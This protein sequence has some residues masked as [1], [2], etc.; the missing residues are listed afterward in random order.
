MNI[1]VEVS[2]FMKVITLCPAAWESNSYLLIQNGEA[3]L[4]DAGASPDK[5]SEALAREQATLKGILLTHGHFDH[6]L[7]I[8]ALREKYNVPVYVH[9]EDAPMLTD[10]RLNA[11]AFFFR[12]ERSWRPAEKL[13]SDG[14]S[15]PFGD[16]R[17]SVIHTPGHTRGSV[18][19]LVGDLLFSGDTLFADGYG[20]TDLEGGDD[21]ALSYSLQKLFK[22]PMTLK[23]YAG[24]GMSTILENAKYNLGF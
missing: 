8:D 5:I 1:Y 13:L 17:I 15:I 3:L 21:A 7:S 20:R 19:Y 16:K 18:C 22:L 10:G 11:Y 24:H 14:D 4:F 12:Q 2:G 6:I 9:R 23:V